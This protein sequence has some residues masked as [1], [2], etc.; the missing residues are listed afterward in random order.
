MQDDGTVRTFETGATRDTSANKFEYGGFL[1][2]LVLHRFATYMHQHRR[3]SDGSL[4]AS[5]NWQKGIPEE[6]YTESLLRHV[7]DFWLWRENFGL[8]TTEEYEDSLCAIIFNA[9][10]LL[11]EHLKRNYRSVERQLHYAEDADLA[12]SIENAEAQREREGAHNFLDFLFGAMVP[13]GSSYE[14]AVDGLQEPREP[15]MS[16]D[17]QE[18]RRWPGAL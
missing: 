2:P 1:S 5:R 9:Q 14:E 11:F 10:G 18:R 13:E 3:Q 15:P 7:I 17:E 8:L 4:R 16:R 6:A 12:R